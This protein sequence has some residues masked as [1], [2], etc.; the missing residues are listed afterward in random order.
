MATKYENYITG[1]DS[2]LGFY[3]TAPRPWDAQ[4]FTPSIA[5][6]ITFIKV[7]LLRYAGSVPG[8]LTA[9]IRATSGGVPTGG[10]LAT[11]TLSAALANVITTTS[12]GEWVTITLGA[13]Y[14][15]LA[16]GVYAIVLKS[17][18]DDTNKPIYW[19]RDA[20]GSAYTDGQGYTT[21]DQGTS[22]TTQ[23]GGV[24]HMFEEWGDASGEP[25]VT[26]QAVTTIVTTTATGNG[27]VTSLGD[28]AVTQHGH[29]WNT[30]GLPDT[31]DSK[32]TNGAKA[33]TGSFTSSL[34]TLTSG[35][36]YY[37]R[38][39]ATNTDGTGYGSEV[40]FTA[41]AVGGEVAGAYEVVEERFH[42]V[43]AYG[44]ERQIQ[45]TVV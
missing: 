18:T 26:T 33:T 16:S 14:A 30:T 4:T 38:A 44:V 17:S 13:G 11:G 5:H 12:P 21:A 7:K 24:D 3:D 8:I 27:N 29:C 39:Y 35:T 25:T 34:T 40:N 42:Y 19:R 15:L 43:D 20:S 45:G 1:D 22:Y 31:N 36:L 41:G 2:N 28:S 37:V 23:G 32:T 9:T 6:T 10:A